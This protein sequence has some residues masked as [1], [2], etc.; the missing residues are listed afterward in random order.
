L[1]TFGS[2]AALALLA[3][4]CG[5]SGHPSLPTP[6][7]FY[8]GSMPFPAVVGEAIVLTPAVS[9]TVGRYTV[10]PSLPSGLSI[11]ELSGIISGTP[12]KPSGATTY[13]VSATGTGVRVA[14]PLVLSVTEPPNGF[15]YVSPVAAIVGVALAPLSPSISGSVDRYTVSP[16]LPLGIVINSTSGTLS[17][18]PSEAKNLAPYTITASSLAGHT[19]FILL[20]TVKP[21]PSG[22]I[23]RH[24]PTRR[25]P[26]PPFPEPSGRRDRIFGKHSCKRSAHARQVPLVL[27]FLRSNRGSLCATDGLH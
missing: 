4:G 2:V 25:G 13:V 20:L 6:K 15:F 11:D 17:G 23:P 24:G 3:V 9:G 26:A 18:T 5:D 14:F 19:R 10:T 12:T 22:A 7:L 16:T 21:A 8:N 1:R 27:T